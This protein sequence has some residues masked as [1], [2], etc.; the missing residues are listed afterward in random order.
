MGGRRGDV[1]GGT[2]TPPRWDPER[3]A[4][5]SALALVWL[6]AASVE[7]KLVVIVSCILAGRRLRPG[8]SV[9]PPG[10]GGSF[11]QG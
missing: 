3:L 11:R 10:T 9:G 1:R 8:V 4:P 6:G 2:R 7:E 5:A